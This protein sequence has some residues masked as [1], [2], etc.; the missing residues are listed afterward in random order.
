MKV[1]F[2][3][4]KEHETLPYSELNALLEIYD[5][6]KNLSI[7]DN[8]V[9]LDKLDDDNS[10]N[11]KDNKN[12]NISKAEYMETI[13]NI[14]SITKRSA[15]IN[16]SHLILFEMLYVDKDLQKNINMFYKNLIDLPLD[17]IL[18]IDISKD[19]F[20]VRALKVP[21]EIKQKEDKNEKNIIKNTKDIKDI[22]KPNSMD[23]ERE[24]GRIIKEKTG[25]KVNLKN[26]SKVVKVIIL[27]DR[28]YL[29]LLI[30]KR[31][32]EYFQKNRPHLRAYFHPGC[33][34]PKLA[35]CMVNLARLK[36]GD[37]LLDPFCGTGG[38]LIEGGFIGCKLIGSDIDD[39]M[40]EGTLLNLK[41]YNLMDNIISIKKWD[42][43]YIKD[44]L[45]TLKIKEVDGIITDPPYGIST[46]KKG[47]IESILN[48]LGNVLKDNG[49]MVFAS[50]KKVYLEDLRLMDMYEIYIHKSLTRYVHVYKKE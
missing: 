22:K 21:K 8:Y 47:D 16:E 3:L 28:I 41:S 4:G 27:K 7:F 5:I 11:D 25:A 29:A 39:R 18:N 9:V 35:R 33:I 10:D 46:S 15:Y 37:I 23:I 2:L 48:S 17:N 43:K 32:K 14:E 30:E 12:N 13:N 19:T 49:Y 24:V 26:P 42:A 31:D 20:A 38:F 6:D 50:S 36:E 40:V 44:Y 34:L 1:G 45:N